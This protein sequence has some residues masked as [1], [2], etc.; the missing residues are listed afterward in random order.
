MDNKNIYTKDYEAIVIGASAGG[1]SALQEI[2]RLLL[3]GYPAPIMIAQHRGNDGEGLLE[4][5]LQDHCQLQ[6]K[7]ADEKEKIKKG[8]VY[9]APPRYHLMIEADKAFSLSSVEANEAGKPSIDILLETAAE[10]YK[11]KLVA[12][13]LTGANDDGADGISMVAGNGGLT[14]AQNPGTAAHSAMPLSAIKTSNVTFVWT[15]EQIGEFLSK[16]NAKQ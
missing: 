11:D 15:L 1:L 7:Q 6:V 5:L 16:L 10:V 3:P 13:I 12:I 4:K 8:Y 9:V 2:L 14:I